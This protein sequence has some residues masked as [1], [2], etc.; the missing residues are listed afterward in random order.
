MPQAYNRND[1]MGSMRASIQNESKAD[2]K[3]AA[4]S[5]EDTTTAEGE[6][7]EK[8]GK[9]TAGTEGGDEGA[10]DEKGG[11]ASGSDNTD[12]DGT[13]AED[14]AGA[15]SEEQAL[16]GEDEGDETPEGDEPADDK[17]PKAEAGKWDEEELKAA[18]DWGLESLKPTAETKKLLKIARDNHAA[19]QAAQQQVAVHNDYLAAVG[20][21]LVNH[22]IKDL[23]TMIQEL[24]GEPI[25]FDVRTEEDQVKEV[26]DGYNAFY[27]ALKA[28]GLPDDAW[29]LV[30]KAI[31]PLHDAA[32]AKVTALEQKMSRKQLKEDVVKDLGHAPVKGKYMDGLK[33]KADKNFI[34]LVKSDPAADK[35]MKAL[36]P[37]FKMGTILQN[38]SKAYAMAPKAIN[39][40]GQA[41]H[42]MKN[43]EKEFLP[44]I[45]KKWEAE[46]KLKKL[47][48]PPPS[49][50]KGESREGGDT[51]KPQSSTQ[52]QNHFVGRR[53][54]A[55]VGKR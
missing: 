24:G 30:T 8:E 37:Y 40:I 54:L 18:K 23:N 26:S 21:S 3:P 14:E 39:E 49:G 44:D 32:K 35:H 43:F 46:L 19:V 2:E 6:T 20:N 33:G 55:R 41:V 10:D 42:F 36:E 13:T 17:K 7:S 38:P 50:N 51:S 52:K 22:D 16:E 11:D 12:S 25:P 45:K 53:L 15:S 48:K 4:A 47:G 9:A 31:A 27:D 5:A 34:D 1:L 28:A 29:A